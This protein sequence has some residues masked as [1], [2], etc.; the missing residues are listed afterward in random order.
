MSKNHRRDTC[1]VGFCSIGT[2]DFVRGSNLSGFSDAEALCKAVSLLG[3][4]EEI[5]RETMKRF[6]L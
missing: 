4:A 5:R 1:K 3:T 6:P 2:N